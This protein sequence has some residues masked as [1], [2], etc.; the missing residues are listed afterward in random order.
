MFR[1]FAVASF[2]LSLLGAV[3]LGA[4]QAHAEN[5]T[6]YTAS[7][8]EVGPVLARVGAATLRAYRE[9]GRKSDG[10]ISLEVLQRIDRPNQFVVLGAWADRKTYESHEAAPH[11]K[12]LNDKLAT[13]L[14]APVDV[15]RL[16]ALSHAPTK[17]SKDPV[18]VVTHIDVIPTAK[19]DA[20]VALKQLAIDSR[21][22]ASNLR[23]DI[24]QQ[25]DRPNHFTAVEEWSS[26]GG[27]DLHQMQ[28]QTRNFRAKLAPVAG[29][30]YDER[31][32]KILK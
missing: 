18:V 31:L 1:G 5:A 12:A 26:R 21:K 13:M 4:S 15:R 17:P 16:S 7:Y 27:F 3:A 10:V 19:D 20:V 29:A 2:A 25:I 24:G 23:F 28:R 9:T 11:T 32:F 30:L 6:F 8:V 14:V 22:H